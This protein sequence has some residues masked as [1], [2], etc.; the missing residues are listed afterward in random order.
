MSS[1][2][3]VIPDLLGIASL[4]PLS[5]YKSESFSSTG[6]NHIY[7]NP[8]PVNRIWCLTHICIGFVSGEVN[9]PILDILDEG[10]TRRVLLARLPDLT[11][12]ETVNFYGMYW[13][14]PGDKLHVRYNV[15]TTSPT[16]YLSASGIELVWTG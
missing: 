10:D 14:F 7:S 9:L 13:A 15:Q 6:A 11:S 3:I 2:G 16:C 8:C 5:L 12:G 1:N 4:K